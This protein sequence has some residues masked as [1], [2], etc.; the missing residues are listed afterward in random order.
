MSC[1]SI[2]R[3]LALT[4][5]CYRVI[6]DWFPLRTEN[7][8]FSWMLYSQAKLR[9]QLLQ[10]D[11]LPDEFPYNN[12]I[13]FDRVVTT[14]K[15]V[16]KEI[17]AVTNGSMVSPSSRL[18]ISRSMNDLSVSIP[19]VKLPSETRSVNEAQVSPA[20]STSSTTSTTAPSVAS[21]GN[22]KSGNLMASMKSVFSPA[23]AAASNVASN[24]ASN[25]IHAVGKVSPANSVTL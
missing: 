11:D 9:F 23:G 16:S 18:E 5:S 22:H 7:P 3:I 17:V 21:S 1:N 6:R 24:V 12:P 2:C 15:L 20:S 8:T 19:S 10:M 4:I 14:P 25:F 13:D